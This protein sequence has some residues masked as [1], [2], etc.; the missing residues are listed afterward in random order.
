MK[1]ILFLSL[2]L[3]AL[4]QLTKQWV[5]RSI[6][7]YGA[8]I[9][10]RDFFNLVNITNTG[11]SF[12]TFGGKNTFFIAISIVALVVVTVLLVIRRPTE[13]WRY[14]S[15]SLLLA[16]I[17]CNLSDRLLYRHVI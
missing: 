14:V 15:L 4:D 8:R 9:V 16:D 1:F 5:M 2:P 3:Y 17:L 6:S 12:A 10:L 13:P 11:A 7:P